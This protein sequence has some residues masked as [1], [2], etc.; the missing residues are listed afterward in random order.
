MLKSIDS[1]KLSK[2]TVVDA[3]NKIDEHLGYIP[4]N[5]TLFIKMH[6]EIIEENL[7]V[8]SELN[9]QISQLKEENEKLSLA[10]KQLIAELNDKN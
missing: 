10:N 5:A 9:M 4:R 2:E 3:T 8:I 1:D 6:G 7:K